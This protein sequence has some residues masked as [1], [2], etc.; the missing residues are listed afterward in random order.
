MNLSAEYLPKD[1]TSDTQVKWSSSAPD[2]A[3]VINGKVTAVGGSAKGNTA[4]I[5]AE[6]AGYKASY[7]IQVETA[8]VTFMKRDGKTA[9]GAPIVVN[10]GDVLSEEIFQ[11]KLKTLGEEPSGS[12]FIGWYTGVGGTGSRFDETSRIHAKE[13]VLY[14]YDAKLYAGFYVLPVGDQTYTGSAIKPKV[15]VFDGTVRPM[16]NCL[17]QKIGSVWRSGRASTIRFL[18][19]IIKM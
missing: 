6:I 1:T 7:T 4:V 3:T 12:R 11:E 19:R 16:A 17:E 13:L 5:T 14:P 18:I 2:V 10:Y 15:E 8:T 9:L